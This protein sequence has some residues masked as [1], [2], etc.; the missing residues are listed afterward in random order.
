MLA[1]IRLSIREISLLCAKAETA[2]CIWPLDANVKVGQI[3]AAA[4]AA[5]GRCVVPRN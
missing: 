3:L 5:G 2:I 4:A 1:R